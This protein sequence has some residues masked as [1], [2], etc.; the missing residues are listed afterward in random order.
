MSKQALT[1]GTPFMLEVQSIL[2]F[3]ICQRLCSRRWGGV[4]FELL[5]CTVEARAPTSNAL[6]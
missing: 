1:P 3:F 6:T 4:E 5:G 2:E